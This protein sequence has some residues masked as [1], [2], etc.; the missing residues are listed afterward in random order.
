MSIRHI[1][2]NNCNREFDMNFNR[3]FV[4][5]EYCGTRIELEPEQ[6]QYDEPEFQNGTQTNEPELE[7]ALDNSET[8]TY[9]EQ[10]DS[11][12]ETADSAPEPQPD[13]SDDSPASYNPAIAQSDYA[14]AEENPATDNPAPAPAWQDDSPTAA[15]PVPEGENKV[16]SDLS[17]AIRCYNN[18]DYA[19]ADKYLEKLKQDEP[20]NFEV[21]FCCC[22]VI[23]AQA[24]ANI[25]SALE[26][27]IAAAANCIYFAAQ[28]VDVRGNLTIEFNRLIKNIIDTIIARR[29]YIMPYD[30][31][32]MSEPVPSFNYRVLGMVDDYYFLI[33]D[34]IRDFQSKVNPNYLNKYFLSVW[35]T[36][37]FCF[38]HEITQLMARDLSSSKFFRWYK[39]DLANRVTN[40]SIYR[41]LCDLVYAYKNIF[42]TLFNRLPYRD[43]KITAYNQIVFLNKWLLKL[44]RTDQF[45][46]TY[47][48]VAQPSDRNALEIEMRNLKIAL[49]K[50]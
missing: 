22:K 26:N 33:M 5:C 3:S 14:S 9:P 37:F 29:L 45:G 34:G 50:V 41:A 28:N 12:P 30:N 43:T 44:K 47:F 32:V 2:C 25:M 16:N 27:Y 6:N 17:A 15:S 49:S 40:D 10:Q 20:Q 46:R 35:D 24:P 4:F 39:S 11:A 21:W 38:A 13:L 7:T 23:A 48:L 18:R 36:G 1:K 31:S 42:M 19:A 8:D